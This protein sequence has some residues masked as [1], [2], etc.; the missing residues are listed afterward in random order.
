MATM[1][2]ALLAQPLIADKQIIVIESGS[3]DG[4]RQVALRYAN[5]PQVQVILQDQP[6]GKGNAVRAGLAQAHGD[7][8]L[9]QD[10]DL[11]YDLHDYD[12]LLE[13]LVNYRAAFV[14][15]SRHSGTWKMRQFADQPIASAS[16]NLGHLFFTALFNLLYGAHMRDPFTMFKVFRRDCLYRLRFECDR[17]DF[18]IELVAKLLRKGYHPVEIPVNYRSRSFRQGKKVSIFRDPPTWVRALL[19]YRL[20]SPLVEEP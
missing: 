7:M 1:M 15:G 8:I 9:I 4:T 5:H 3:H 18:D 10:A 2:D 19:K 13:P 12:A 17:F 16:L 11:E 20:T 6:R 14:L